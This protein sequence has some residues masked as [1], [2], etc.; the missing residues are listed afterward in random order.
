M[1]RSLPLGN[2]WAVM[3]SARNVLSSTLFSESRRNRPQLLGVFVAP[4]I[5]CRVPF[6]LLSRVAAFKCLCDTHQIQ[7][8][9]WCRRGTVAQEMK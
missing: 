5:L 2:V 3:V 1:Y 7:Y 9:F 4:A 6:P 8:E